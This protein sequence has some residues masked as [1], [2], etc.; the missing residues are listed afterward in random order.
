MKVFSEWIGKQ[1]SIIF[2][3]Q[4]TDNL[5][6]STPKFLFNVLL[7]NVLTIST[8]RY[9]QSDNDCFSRILPFEIYNFL[10]CSSA[11]NHINLKVDEAITNLTDV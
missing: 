10:T 7:R 4:E 2:I 1:F 3:N 6:N 8:K 5:Y 9:P 11:R